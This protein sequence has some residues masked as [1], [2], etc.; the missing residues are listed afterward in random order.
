MRGSHALESALRNEGAKWFPGKD[1]QGRWKAHPAP[2]GRRS[3]EDNAVTVR[4]SDKCRPA[5]L[6]VMVL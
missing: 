3:E 6:G 1:F 5:N 2:Y 4:D